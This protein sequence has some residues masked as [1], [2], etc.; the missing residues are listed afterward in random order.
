[1]EKIS[2]QFRLNLKFTLY[3]Y[4]KNLPKQK[5][6]IQGNLVLCSTLGYTKLSA[7]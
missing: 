5:F 7:K 2:D 4:A 3:F 1:M 6:E